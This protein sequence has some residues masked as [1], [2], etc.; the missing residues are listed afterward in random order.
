MSNHGEV[1]DAEQVFWDKF[2]GRPHQW[3]PFLPFTSSGGFE[4]L[5]PLRKDLDTKQARSVLLLYSTM[6]YVH[7]LCPRVGLL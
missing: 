3:V 2:L 7:V 6:P 1:P 4:D 5:M